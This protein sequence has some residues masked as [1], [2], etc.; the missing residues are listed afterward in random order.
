MLQRLLSRIKFGDN[1]DTRPD[2]K[3]G[4]ISTSLSAVLNGD[5]SC[6]LKTVI[7]YRVELS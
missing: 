4:T 3:A 2:S 5:E 1:K 7:S 6:G